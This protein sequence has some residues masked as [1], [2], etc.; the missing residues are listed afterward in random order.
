[1]ARLRP[2]ILRV[3]L[4][5]DVGGCVLGAAKDNLAVLG[6]AADID[7][8]R[9]VRGRAGELHHDGRVGGALEVDKVPP[10]GGV[11]RLHALEGVDIKATTLEVNGAVVGSDGALGY[12]PRPENVP[13]GAPR[14]REVGAV[15]RLSGG[16]GL[17]T[18]RGAGEL[19][20]DDCP[21][22]VHALDGVKGAILGQLDGEVVGVEVGHVLAEFMVAEGCRAPEDGLGVVGVKDFAVELAGCA[23]AALVS[24]LALRVQ[25]K[26]GTAHI[27]NI[28]IDDLEKSD[29]AVLAKDVDGLGLDRRRVH[30]LPLQVLTLDLGEGRLLGLDGDRLDGLGAIDG[31]LGAG[32]IGQPRARVFQSSV[33]MLLLE[34]KKGSWSRGPKSRWGWMGEAFL[35]AAWPS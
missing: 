21:L 27:R 12:A 14:V 33:F 11:V 17:E 32:D 3:V 35:T 18:G 34:V 13:H 20:V 19:E 6:D 15:Q 23:D 5:L 8:S 9:A 4:N 29:V 31:L 30:G 1:M 26:R 25:H 2:V 28:A 22:V 10:A 16:T 7:K 24:M